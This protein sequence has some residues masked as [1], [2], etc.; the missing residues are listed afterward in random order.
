MNSP[1]VPHNFTNYHVMQ[2]GA[3]VLTTAFKIEGGK[4]EQKKQNKR[5]KIEE[6]I[7]PATKVEG[8]E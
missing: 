6:R 8:N 4:T 7:K 1:C 3:I 2:W 5:K